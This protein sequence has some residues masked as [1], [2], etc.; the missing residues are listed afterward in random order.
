MDNTDKLRQSYNKKVHFNCKNDDQA[1]TDGYVLFLEDQIL[2]MFKIRK[3]MMLEAYKEGFGAAMDCL[4]AA[5]M[6]LQEKTTE[7]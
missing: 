4:Q 5:N 2:G 3:E 7:P 1:F 6:K